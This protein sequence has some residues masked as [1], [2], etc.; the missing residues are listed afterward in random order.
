MQNFYIY[1]P[2]ITKEI[3]NNVIPRSWPK[4]TKEPNKMLKIDKNN[5]NKY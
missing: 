3:Y 4:M 5:I 2:K 1:M